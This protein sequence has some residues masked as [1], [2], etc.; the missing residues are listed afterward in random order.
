LTPEPEHDSTSNSEDDYGLQRRLLR[1]RT[2][3]SFAVGFGIV[4][5]AISRL[6]LDWDDVYG[7]IRGAHVGLLLLAF[8]ANYGSIFIRSLRWRNLLDSAEVR[9]D[10]GYEMPRIRGMAAIY[11]VSWYFNCLLPAK[12]GDAYRGYL[13]KTRSRTPFSTALGTVVAE[14]IA[15]VVALALLL[16]LSGFLVFGTRVP[17]SIENWLIL[18]AAIGV[19]LV[20]GFALVF[21]YRRTLRRLIPERAMTHYLR[22]EQGMLMSYRKVPSLVSLTTVIWF[23]EGARM[24]LIGLSIGAGLGVPEAVFIALLASLLTAVPATPAGLGFVELGIV[25]AAVVMGFSDG[26][27]AS[28]AVLDRFVAYWSVL[29]IGTGVFLIT[30]WRWRGKQLASSPGL[31]SSN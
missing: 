18:A 4:A 26:V 14:R 25:G 3:L 17:D 11:M 24:Y 19:S 13:L 23:L 31:H 6:N 29:V 7:Q 16:V 9:P 21:K 27:A 28:L 22:L 12:L 10:P 8:A 1:P 30:R 15:D 5:L 2:V 20:V